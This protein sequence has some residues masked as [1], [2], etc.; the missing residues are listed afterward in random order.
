MSTHLHRQLLATSGS[1]DPLPDSGAQVS[2][3]LVLAP[4][5]MS[6]LG[7]GGLLLPLG[8]CR[9]EPLLP[10]QRVLQAEGPCAWPRGLPRGLSP[11]RLTRT[12]LR[13]RGT[14][15]GGLQG[16][17]RHLLA[18]CPAPR[19][20]RRRHRPRW[21]AARRV[22]TGALAAR[23]VGSPWRA[24][25]GNVGR[26]GA[27]HLQPAAGVADTSRPG[28]RH[29]RRRSGSDIQ[30]SARVLG[31]PSG[32]SVPARPHRDL[33]ASKV[34]LRTSRAIGLKIQGRPQDA[35]QAVRCSGA[36]GTG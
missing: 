17:L 16:R 5:R 31:I 14:S 32:P 33:G 22:R 1:W 12:Q 25:G 21:K 18:P 27:A 30:V 9:K 13:P 4:G 36:R 35:G 29:A 28:D 24:G 26:R 3:R 23:P 11:R 15:A 20:P 2:T 19:P 34:E 7:Q 6:S 10:L 8:P